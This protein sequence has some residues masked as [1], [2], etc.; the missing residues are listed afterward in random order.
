MKNLTE[1]KNMSDQELDNYI[2][3]VLWF[4]KSVLD[5]IRYFEGDEKT[6]LDKQ[7]YRFDMSGYDYLQNQEILKKF[8]HLGIFEN[9]SNNN[10]LV[11]LF[12][13]GNCKV[14]FNIESGIEC[15]ILDLETGRGTTE[16]IRIILRVLLSEEPIYK[17]R[18]KISVIDNNKIINDEHPICDYDFEIVDG[19]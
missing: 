12:Y 11:I 15:V 17:Y 5:S 14:K 6:F 10:M 7:H 13:K 2:R 1:I 8:S 19:F 18:K 16:I 4:D 9:E 3:E